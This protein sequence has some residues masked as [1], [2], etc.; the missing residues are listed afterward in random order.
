MTMRDVIQDSNVIAGTLS[1]NSMNAMVLIDSRATRSFI[2]M[3]FMSKVNNKTQ[4]LEQP[5][6]IEIADQHR[7]PV[8]KICPQC[9]INISGHH[10]YAD[11]IPFKL[12]EFDVILG[13]D[14]LATSNAFIDCTNNKVSMRTSDGQTIVFQGQRQAKKFLTMIQAKRLLRQGYQAYLAHVIDNR[15]ET[16]KIEDI[17]VVNNFYRCIF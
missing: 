12:R 4:P 3:D 10:F 16:P 7:I 2:S 1:V 5:L 9:V 11:L 8:D 6:M 17:P 15:N 14:W 13:M